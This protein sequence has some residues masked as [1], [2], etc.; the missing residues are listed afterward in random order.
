MT[1]FFDPANWVVFAATVACIGACVALHYGVL[2]GCAHLLPALS[3][4]KP[5]RVLLLIFIVV[6]THGVEIWLF[7]IGYAVLCSFEVFGVIHGTAAV[8]S[9]LDYAYFSGTV[10]STTGFGDMVP[11][12]AIRFMVG[13]EAL[14]GLVMITWSASFTFLQMESDW[15]K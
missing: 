14:T 3:R 9:I 4:R 12:G 7:A 11:L 15:P 8:N 5:P 1:V 10:Y 13:M 2:L 6:F